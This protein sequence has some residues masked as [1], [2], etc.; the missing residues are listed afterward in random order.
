M[1]G[2]GAIV[3]PTSLRVLRRI[4]LLLCIAHTLYDQTGHTMTHK[5]IQH[6]TIIQS[7]TLFVKVIHCMTIYVEVMQRIGHRVGPYRSYVI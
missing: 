1:G 7:M 4:D 5:V 6:M 3:T 2:I